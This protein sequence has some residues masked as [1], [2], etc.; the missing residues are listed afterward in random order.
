MIIIAI[1][2]ASQWMWKENMKDSGGAHW[3]RIHCE[4]IIIERQWESNIV[5]KRYTEHYTL[6][7]PGRRMCANI[8]PGFWER[9][10]DRKK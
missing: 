3:A 4:M 6:T 8:I 7:G 2:F 1:A 5:D 9:T 10:G